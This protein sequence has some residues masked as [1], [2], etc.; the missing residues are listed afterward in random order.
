MFIICLL[1]ISTFYILKLR[2][3]NIIYQCVVKNKNFV[4]SKFCLDYDFKPHLIYRSSIFV[5]PITNL[6]LEFWAYFYDKNSNLIYE[7]HFNFKSLEA[8]I[9]IT[10]G[11]ENFVIFKNDLIIRNVH[12]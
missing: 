5:G 6:E 1:F 2:S 8:T 10:G 11:H 3:K 9:V 7:S 4:K 12:H